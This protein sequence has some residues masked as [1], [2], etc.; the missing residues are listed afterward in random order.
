MQKR[1][2]KYERLNEEFMREISRILASEIKDPRIHP[3]TSVLSTDIS[4]DLHYARI[5]VSVFGGDLEKKRTAEGLKSAAPK[6]R[7]LLAKNMN[8]RITPELSFVVDDTIEY[9]AAI[10]RKIRDV[11]EAAEAEGEENNEY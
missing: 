11:S 5:Y 9:E 6:I 10:A 2:I 7:R 1:S 3:M 8:M 4:P